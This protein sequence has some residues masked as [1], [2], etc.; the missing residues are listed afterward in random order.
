MAALE[1]VGAGTTVR[2]AGYPGFVAG[3]R[4]YRG[5]WLL[6]VPDTREDPDSMNWVYGVHRRRLHQELA[7]AAGGA[8]LVTGAQVGTVEAGDPAGSPARVTWR[9]DGN[10]RSARA[11][12]VV[13]A[14]GI[15]S[16]VCTR[17]V[18]ACR[19][20]YS[21]KTSWRAVTSTTGDV[22]EHFTI[23]WGPGTEFG[24]VR[25]SHEEVYWYGY[26]QYPAGTALADE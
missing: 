16:T 8:D 15:G 22:D 2:E 11:D 7:T 4:N 6:R 10:D 24:A 14:D 9:E 5:R 13:A 20:A 18:P 21:G 17:L 3:T 25:I 1:D 19:V 26:F 12:L 23:T